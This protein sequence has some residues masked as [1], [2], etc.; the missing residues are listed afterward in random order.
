MQ[1]AFHDF[2]PLLIL[3]TLLADDEKTEVQSQLNA[4]VFS[5]QRWELG[6]G[7]GGQSLAHTDRMDC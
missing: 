6:F 5:A 1:R 7:L 2:F 4:Y 3:T